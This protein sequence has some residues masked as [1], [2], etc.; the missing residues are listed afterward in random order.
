VANLTGDMFAFFKGRVALYAILKAMGIGPEDEIILPGFTCVVVPSAITYLGA[1]PVYVDI[2]PETYNIDQNKIEQRITD[3]TKLIIAQHTFG[4]PAEME[5]ILE[6]ARKYHLYVIEDSCHTVGSKYKG[7]EVGT[8]GDAVF[9]SSQ[10]SKP[11]TTGLGGW[12]VVNNP[13]LEARMKK[14][15]QE[16]RYPSVGE[17][18]ILKL[19]YFLYS[20]LLTPSFFWL[21][22]NIYRKL[23]TLGMAVGSST[24]EELECQMPID[25]KKKMSAWQRRILDRK[26]ENISHLIRHRNWVVSQYEKSLPEIGF[27]KVKLDGDLETVF[28]SYPILVKDKKRVLDEAKKRRI[29]IG[30]WFVS[31]IHPN[32]SGWDKVGYQKGMCP[33]AEEVCQHVINLPMHPGIGKRQ[34]E[35]AVRLL[36]N[37]R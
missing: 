29:E 15:H 10:W 34:I 9:F 2:V 5:R 7:K 14:V 22:R 27:E 4:I 32:L 23:S 26:L 19:Q 36:A 18:S 31:P 6:I 35:S 24:N 16:F 21:A 28:L 20:K 1:K 8:F 12:A 11:V 37:S 17:V 13:E 3:K 30:D 25:Y 33:L